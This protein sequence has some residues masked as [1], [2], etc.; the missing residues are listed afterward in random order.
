MPHHTGTAAAGGIAV[1]AL[2]GAVTSALA[3]VPAG[4]PPRWSA[5]YVVLLL[6][7]A[8]SSVI[9]IPLI[10][11]RVRQYRPHL[12]V[13]ER[14]TESRAV[15]TIENPFGAPTGERHALVFALRDFDPL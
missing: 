10:E 5:W 2:I 1:A 14:S 12:I 3:D 4:S 11:L 9:A 15:V 7:V 13:S 6:A 8:A